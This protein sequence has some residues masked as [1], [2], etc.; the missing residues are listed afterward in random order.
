MIGEPS[1]QD[2]PR[3]VT[4]ET[5]S[6]HI[7]DLNARV[8]RWVKSKAAPELQRLLDDAGI[9]YALTYSVA[10]IF[11]DPHYAARGNIV[12]V[13]TRIGP[14]QMQGV[15]PRFAGEAPRSI[16]PAPELGEHTAD[17]LGSMLGLSGEAMD[18]LA[19]REVIDLGRR[20]SGRSSD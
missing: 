15:V 14:I 2:D 10:D 16:S 3:Y 1:W 11:A 7:H 13:G 19:E 8:G 5:R 17:V 20:Q 9:A 18:A 4:P 12:S 6:W